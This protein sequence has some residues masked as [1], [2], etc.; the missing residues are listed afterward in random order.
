MSWGP[1]WGGLGCT[2]MNWDELGGH[3]S[4]PQYIPAHAG[5]RG[6]VLVY[7]GA[8]WAVS[9]PDSGSCG[10]VSVPA[11]KGKPRGSGA[12]SKL[13]KSRT[14]VRGTPRQPKKA[15]PKTPHRPLTQSSPSPDEELLPEEPLDVGSIL[16]ELLERVLTEHVLA[17][18]ARQ[19]VPFT[20]S[21]AR[22]AMLF[23][24]EWRF[25]MRDDGD[26]DP[27]GDPD[28]E[29]DGVWR[30][31][32]E[33]QSCRW[34]S[35]TS[36]AVLVEDASLPS[37]AVPSGDVPVSDEAAGPLVCPAE[38][39]EAVPVPAV[40]PEQPLCQ[41]PSAAA[42]APPEHIPGDL[43]V[44]SVPGPPLPEPP[45]APRCPGRGRRPSRP[46]RPSRPRPAPPDAPR[47]PA[48]LPAPLPEPPTEA[49]QESQEA[50]TELGDQEPPSAGSSSSSL[51]SLRSR[52]AS[53]GP[54]VPRLGVRRGAARWVFPEVRVVDVSTEPERVRSGASRSRLAP[55]GSPQALPGAGRAA[56]A[57][58]QLCDPWLASAR[59]AP[60]VTV[61]WGG[62]ERRGPTPV[63]H[64]D[65]EQE[66]D[67]AVRRA[68]KDLKPI[69][70][71]P[72]CR[73]S[74]YGE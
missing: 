63:G 51:A 14:P 22:D 30:E 65:G 26:P 67:E 13:E 5:L 34:D 49:P 47:P 43:T 25:P 36:G 4:T 12:K 74:E 2:G 56:K 46:S 40:P 37:E 45:I 42:A 58:A 29:R 23:V 48:P 24:A 6:G 3:P 59:L 69:L 53:R 71:Y 15:S 11:Q 32:E 21:R 16:D 1:C 54:C 28:P 20:V 72:E 64:G 33:P 66:E 35:G 57:E 61:R 44:V 60:G 52:R 27:G 41:A 73:I 70:P 19:R 8:H 31:D 55:P 39:P 68:E 9:R 10:G 17:A 50:T 18:A 38:V 7:T 62:S